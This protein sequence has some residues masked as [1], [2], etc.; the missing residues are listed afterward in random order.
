MEGI[1][2][3]LALRPDVALVD[4][5]LPGVDGYVVAK[6]LREASGGAPYLVALTGYGSADDR[7]RALAA[8]FDAHMVK[9]VDSSTLF[10]LLS[11]A[12]QERQ[13]RSS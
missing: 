8:G 2:T 12:T 1:A 4:I 9:P 3:G 10:E 13:L 7:R 5:G 6:R 11:R